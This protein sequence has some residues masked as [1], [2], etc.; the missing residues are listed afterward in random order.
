MLLM[1]PDKKP[2]PYAAIALSLC[3]LVVLGLFG[4]LLLADSM[5]TMPGDGAQP[6]LR[7]K[8]LMLGALLIAL[9]LMLLAAAGFAITGIRAGRTVLANQVICG[10]AVMMLLFGAWLAG[11]FR[12]SI[13]S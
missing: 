5:M 3:G 4:M 8:F 11:L 7:E 6:W 10:L 2:L 9:P 13:L 1:I 12:M